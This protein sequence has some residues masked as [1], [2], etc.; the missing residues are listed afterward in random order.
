MTSQ[1]E[2]GMPAWRLVV[3]GIEKSF[4]ATRALSGVDFRVR[5][6]EVHAIIGENGAGKSTLMKILSGAITPDAGQVELDGHVLR[7]SDPRQSIADGIAMIYQELNLASDL[8]VAENITLGD[9]PRPSGLRGRLGLI[10]GRQRRAIARDALAKLQVTDLDLDQPVGD[11]S[12]ASQ[13]MVEIARAVR[14]ERLKVLILDEPT[15]SLT[16]VDTDHLLTVIDRLK[17]TGV[18]VVYISHFLEECSQ[19]CDR[20]TVLRDGCSV[21]TGRIEK[22]RG[23]DAG[24]VLKDDSAGLNNL[25]TDQSEMPTPMSRIVEMMVGRDVSDLYPA[26]Q[27]IAANGQAN[28]VLQ[29]TD[30]S[31]QQSL[32]LHPGEIVGLAGLIG[33]G[34]TELARGLFGLDALPQTASFSVS[35]SAR[36]SWQ[37][38]FGLLSEDRKNEGLLLDR[39]LTENMTLTKL[40]ARPQSMIGSLAWVSD[41]RLDAATN[42]MRQRLDVKSGSARQHVGE[43]S[44]GNQQKIALGRL[45]HHECNVLLLDEPTRGIDIGSKQTIYQVIAKLADE[46]KAILM[47][48][49]YLPELLG[50]CDRIGVMSRGNLVDVRPT[51]Q[52]DEP[53]LLS[54]AI[55]VSEPNQST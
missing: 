11:L 47:T 19:I 4:G 16:R 22:T 53:S 36:Q 51:S 7:G 2:S 21:G 43:L 23:D 34:R 10:D 28:P 32:T 14:S 50:M 45:L 25:Q 15:S 3:R 46:G 12:I 38:G 24:S 54:A 49:S 26:R 1:S 30:P 35:R 41:T 18:S 42:S 44:G 31:S 13:Q 20:F 39:S 27:S 6:G 37:R 9:P 55:G 5:R 17:Q 29:W 48:S 33:A 8:S 52:W 40:D